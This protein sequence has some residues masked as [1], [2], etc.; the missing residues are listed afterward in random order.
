M[1]ARAYLLVPV[2]LLAA[3]AVP[4]AHAGLDC[5]ASAT[6]RLEYNDGI[7]GSVTVE[8]DCSS[9]PNR[10][11]VDASCTFAGVLTPNNTLIVEYGGTATLRSNDLLRLPQI[12]HIRCRIKNSTEDSDF[13]VLANGPASAAAGSTLLDDDG[14]KEWAVEDV[15]VCVSGLGLWGNF[16]PV[17]VDLIEHCTTPTP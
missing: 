13:D 10:Y 9:G 5:T 17:Q 11:A 4:A 7:R 14:A 15:T 12:T 16:D 8:G 3:V 2:G 1:S 6:A